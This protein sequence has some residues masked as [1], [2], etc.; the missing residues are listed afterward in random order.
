MYEVFDTSMAGC[1]SDDTVNI[2]QLSQ[3][4]KDP[5]MCNLLKVCPHALHFTHVDMLF[6]K[7]KYLDIYIYNL[8]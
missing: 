1:D 7:L 5:N 4:R 3:H 8:Q 2:I 6:V